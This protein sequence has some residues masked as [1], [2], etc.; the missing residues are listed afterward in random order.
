PADKG[1]T[2]YTRDFKNIA[3]ATDTALIT[4]TSGKTGRLHELFCTVDAAQT[5]IL[6]DGSTAKSATF[7]F[8][9]TGGVFQWALTPYPYVETTANTA[10][11]L[12][13]S[14]SANV[15]CSYRYVKD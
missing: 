3:A 8:P 1:D 15:N 7:R 5:L 14:T 10:L 4:A 2:T 12:T 11:N 9:S 13:T 6:K